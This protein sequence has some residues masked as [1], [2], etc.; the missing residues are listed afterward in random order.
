[1]ETGLF[2]IRGLLCGVAA[3]W[4]GPVKTI[5]WNG[6]PGAVTFTFDDGLPSQR[7]NVLP[8]LKSRGLHATFFLIGNL[9]FRSYKAAWIQAARDGNELANHTLSH[10]HMPGISTPDSII[11]QIDDQATALRA[12][13]P[14][15]ESVTLAYPY[16][17]SDDLVDSLANLENFMVRSCGG[18]AL[19]SW[20]SNPSNW[21]R[22]ASMS[23]DSAHVATA[24]T[25]L[26]RA[27]RDSSWL[28]TLDHGVGGDYL[29][30]ATSDLEK[31]LDKAMAQ[32]LWIGT[33]QEVGAYWRA[34]KVM[35]TTTPIATLDGW[36]LHWSLPHPQMPKSIPLR[37][38]FNTTF[39]GDSVVIFQGN[40]LLAPDSDGSYRIEFTKLE[41]EVRRLS[42]N[43][44][45]PHLQPTLTWKRSRSG[46]LEIQGLAKG[47]YEWSLWNFGGRELDMG[48]MSVGEAPVFIR[49]AKGNTA[50]FLVKLRSKGSL[51]PQLVLK[52]P[53]SWDD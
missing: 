35:D 1:M 5:P 28:V 32:K 4:S 43:H 19:F 31:L 39:F 8:A 33:Y 22:M 53:G 51:D 46:L 7:A 2:W 17:E 47:D 40:S 36:K 10:L 42:T 50:A 20:K 12:L 13:D 14:S 30:I 34:A 52:V 24:L 11:H 6:Y 26:E 49:L 27:S 44:L 16:C 41:L 45:R 21:M 15:V 29:D 37:V 3:A 48:I 18:T 9:N 25:S 23:M 38:K